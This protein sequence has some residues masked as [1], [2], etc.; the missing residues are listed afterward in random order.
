MGLTRETLAW[1]TLR[2]DEHRQHYTIHLIPKRSG[3]R[4]TLLAPNRKLKSAQRWVLKQILQKVPTGD[5]VHGFATGRSIVSNAAGHT[6]ADVVVS[7]DL[8]NF[9]PSI[10]RA[11]VRGLFSWLGYGPEVA[12]TLSLLCTAADRD[13]ARRHLPQGAPTSPALSNLICWRLDRRLCG[14]AAKLSATYT[15]YADDITFSGRKELKNGMKRFLPLLRK[16]LGEEGFAI[17]KR[18]LRFMRKGSRQEVTGLVVNDRTGRP[19]EEVRLL[20]AILHNCRT[21]GVAS[22]NRRND[23]AFLDRLAG[24]IGVVRM[25]NPAQGD[26]LLAELKAVR[27]ASPP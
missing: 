27:E 2:G 26:R 14:L 5:C 8:V 21:Q 15:R 18:K 20:R 22:Q 19:R 10:S 25:C 23:P 9:F 6:R 17:N 7:A 16:I 1:L 13:G 11:S 12:E 24:R 4:R 3:G